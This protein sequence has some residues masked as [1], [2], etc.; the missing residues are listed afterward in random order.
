MSVMSIAPATRSP[1]YETVTTTATDS[2]ILAASRLHS[3]VARR[4]SDQVR[5][6]NRLTSI[7]PSRA[8]M[9]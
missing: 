7:T 5:A 6:R 8:Y 3:R 2:P 1:L 9:A 4:L